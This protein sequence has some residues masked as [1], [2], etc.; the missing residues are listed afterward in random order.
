MGAPSRR[1]EL[2]LAWLANLAYVLLGILLMP[3][4]SCRVGVIAH[5]TPN[6]ASRYIAIGVLCEGD[7]KRISAPFMDYPDDNQAARIHHRLTACKRKHRFLFEFCVRF[8]ILLSFGWRSNQPN[9]Q[10]LEI[11]ILGF[12]R[13]Q[14][15]VN[16]FEISK[17]F[18]NPKSHLN[19]ML[20][21]YPQLFTFCEYDKAKHNF[22]Y[23]FRRSN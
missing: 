2:L 19:K 15:L 11:H 10:N 18:L 4:P 17:D 6:H 1:G 16:S 7:T 22:P 13:I 14:K 23:G 20:P 8:V 5:G 3:K 12:C 9:T 21:I